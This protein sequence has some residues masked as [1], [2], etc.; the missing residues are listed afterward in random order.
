MLT[1]PA[2]LRLQLDGAAL[3]ANWRWLA[4]QGGGAAT[5]AAIKADGYGLGAQAVRDKLYAAGCRDFFVATWA[6]AAALMPMPPGAA[7]SVPRGAG[8]GAS[9]ALQPG[10]QRG[11]LSGPRLWL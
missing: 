6:G 9:G 11:H 10:E 4:Q 2:P 8:G 1:I 3:A 5:G 7:L